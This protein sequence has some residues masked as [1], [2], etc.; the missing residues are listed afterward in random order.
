MINITKAQGNQSTLKDGTLTD[1]TIT[2][3][4]EELCSLPS[5][6]SPEEF[7]HIRDAMHKLMLRAAK[8]TREVEQQIAES[9]MQQVLET[10]NRQLNFLKQENE[11]LAEFV[12]THT[13]EVA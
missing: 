11:K 12:D 6:L 9:R 8:E 1:W 13:K 7:F 10:G 4:E 5:H 2:L 3:G